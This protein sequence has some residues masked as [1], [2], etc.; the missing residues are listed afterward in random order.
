MKKIYYLIGIVFLI[1]IALAI[2]LVV[3][4]PGN[5][6]DY[7]A[8]TLEYMPVCGVDGVT[9]GNACMAG[10]VEIEYQGECETTQLANPASEFCED[11][12]GTV[13]IRSSQNGEYGVC[14]FQ[15]N[16][17]CE[18]WMFYRGECEAGKYIYQD[19]ACTREFNPVCG[20]NG[21]TYSN[22]CVAGDIPI[23]HE[24][25]C[26]LVKLNNLETR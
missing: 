23:V 5:T 20:E 13:D 22:P 18:E 8:C 11:N 2:L 19:K 25:S 7:K 16:S 9:Y 4:K 3:Q 17:E 10:D 21:V 14:V 6:N 26:W 12:N 1:G 15:D 24:G